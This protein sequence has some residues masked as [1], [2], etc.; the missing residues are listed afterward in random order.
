MERAAQRKLG[1][2]PDQLIQRPKDGQD[3]SAWMHENREMFGIPENAEGYEIKPPE[4]FGDGGLQWD[5]DLEG[6]ARAIAHKH[7]LGGAALQELSDLYAGKV[8]ALATDAGDQLAKANRE[9]MASLQS[10]WGPQTDARLAQARAGAEALAAAAGLDNSA[11]LNIGQ[12][13]SRESGDAATIKLFQKVGEMMAEDTTGLIRT[14]GGALT[15]TP[16]DAR[17]E[18]AK[19]RAPGGAYYEA[20]AKGDQAEVKR[21]APRIAELDKIA[22]A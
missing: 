1:S 10:E 21:L 6:Q 19:M 4:G 18:L 12:V 14:Q 17:A 2:K 20:V 16:A 7:G 5:K 13:L 11:L 3:L 22:S 9:M 8:R 15:T